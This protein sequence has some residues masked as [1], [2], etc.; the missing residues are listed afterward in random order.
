[1]LSGALIRK[2]KREYAANMP[3]GVCMIACYLKI[4]HLQRQ[5]PQMPCMAMVMNL[6]T[7]CGKPKAADV[8]PMN[9][10]PNRK[11]HT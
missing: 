10:V 6:P 5:K 9:Q 3:V 4:T 8:A 1:M 11:F 2:L 7:V